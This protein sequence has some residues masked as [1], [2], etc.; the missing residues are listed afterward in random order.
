MVSYGEQVRSLT[1]RFPGDE[2]RQIARQ[3]LDS[4]IYTDAKA[5]DAHI[6]LYDVLARRWQF[7]PP[8]PMLVK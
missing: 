3:A 1:E 7:V 5:D 6:A 2:L 8:L 4:V